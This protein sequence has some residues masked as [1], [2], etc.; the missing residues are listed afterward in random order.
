MCLIFHQAPFESLQT[1]YIGEM[2]RLSPRLHQGQKISFCT[3]CSRDLGFCKTKK[4]FAISHSVGCLAFTQR[5][6]V[7]PLGSFQAYN[8][9][10][11]VV[12]NSLLAAQENWL[13]L[14]GFIEFHST[15]KIIVFLVLLCL[16]NNGHLA[17]SKQI[18]I[19]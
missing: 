7:H 1:G 12:L 19:H 6:L 2:A 13:L 15:G 11:F 10:V 14:N 9:G 4:I 17:L 18:P 16:L 5:I 8:S 3:F